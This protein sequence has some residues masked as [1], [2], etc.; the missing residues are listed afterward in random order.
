MGNC[1]NE[2][3]Y[4]VH[5]NFDPTSRNNKL[6]RYDSGQT[7]IQN[8]LENKIESNKNTFTEINQGKASTH[9]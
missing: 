5:Q 6:V 4:Q 2:K 3:Q 7:F 8:V 1:L 9:K